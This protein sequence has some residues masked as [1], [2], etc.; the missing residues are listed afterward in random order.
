[1][2]EEGEE[3]STKDKVTFFKER[4]DEVILHLIQDDSA[5]YDTRIDLFD[6]N[7]VKNLVGSKED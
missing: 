4:S 6:L 7:D 1:M 3:F 2:E 5:F